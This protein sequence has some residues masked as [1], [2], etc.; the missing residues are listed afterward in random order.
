MTLDELL[1][2]EGIRKTIAAYTVAGDRL[3]TEDFVAVFT[4]DGVLETDGVP[5]ED[6]FRYQGREA[7]RAW[8][9]RWKTPAG[10][11]PVHQASFIRHHL[12]TCHIE[13]T[14][15]DTASARTYW[16]A[17]T[18]LGPDHCGYYVDEFRKVGDAWL[19]A[20]RRIR[21]DWRIDGSLHRNAI[22]RTRG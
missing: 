13:L 2:R 20:R 22:A 11:A 9:D 10:A 1:A 6:A 19:I 8:M 14:G 12:A 4:E 16:T 5:Q 15:A 7:L 17:Y 3:R 18:D 21:L